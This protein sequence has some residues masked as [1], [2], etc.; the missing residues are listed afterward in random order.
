M[1]QRERDFNVTLLQN[2]IHR[3]DYNDK[4]SNYTL[5]GRITVDE[6]KAIQQGLDA[7]KFST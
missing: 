3:L 7:L 4:T 1:D 2:L 6:I 5:T